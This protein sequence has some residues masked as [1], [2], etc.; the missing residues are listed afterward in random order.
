[1]QYINLAVYYRLPF[2]KWLSGL[3]L[4][5]NGWNNIGKYQ[6]YSLKAHCQSCVHYHDSAKLHFK[7]FRITKYLSWG[8]KRLPIATPAK[9]NFSKLILKLIYDWK[10][11][12]LISL[13]LFLF[14]LFSSFL[15]FF[16]ICHWL[17]RGHMQVKIPKQYQSGWRLKECFFMHSPRQ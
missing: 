8:V 3:I 1:M 12:F 16:F 7:V 10:V 17:A 9:T 15:F 5:N 4:C 13:S 11:F 6:L 14:F 2:S